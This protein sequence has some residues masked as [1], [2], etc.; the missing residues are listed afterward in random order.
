[1]TVEVEDDAKTASTDGRSAEELMTGKLNM[2][3][4]PG[5]PKLLANA[6]DEDVTVRTPSRVTMPP[7]SPVVL[8]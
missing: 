8:S 7:L 2:A 5:P 6:P 1:M 3:V 4:L